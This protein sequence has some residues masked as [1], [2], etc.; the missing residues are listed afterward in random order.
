[1]RTS[2]VAAE[3]ETIQ[4]RGR[5]RDPETQRSILEATRDLLLEVGYPGLT[6]EGV[7]AH[8]GAGKATIYRWWATKGEL[9]L[10]AAADHLEIGVVPD[11]GDTRRDLLIAAEQL[12]ATFSDRLAGIVIFTVIAGLDDDPKVAATFRDTWVY[13][14][15]KSAADAIE[16]GMERGDLPAATDVQLVLDVVVGT[17]FQR[18]LVMRD[19]MTEGLPEAIVDLILPPA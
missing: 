14:W 1:M 2:N 19:P 3:R 5:P 13:P 9:V 15:R 12:T 4:P 16:R 8:A 17:V 18:T 11:T 10:E 7:A 6:I